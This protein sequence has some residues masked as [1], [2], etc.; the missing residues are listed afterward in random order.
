MTS[1]RIS[2]S[3][4]ITVISQVGSRY[5]G[6]DVMRRILPV[7]A[8]PCQKTTPGLT[9]RKTLDK[10]RLK[11]LLQ[12]TTLI[13]LQTLSNQEN[14]RNCYSQEQSKRHDKSSPRALRMESWDR[15]KALARELP[16]GLVVWIWCLYCQGLGS[17]HR[18]TATSTELTLFGPTSAPIL[19]LITRSC[20]FTC[21]S[22]FSVL[23]CELLSK[24]GAWYHPSPSPSPLSS[25]APSS[26]LPPPAEMPRPSKCLLNGMEPKCN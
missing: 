6:F 23:A 12:S 21:L 18:I 17:Q 25:L 16:G 15:T 26:S 8:L 4:S 10:F 9:M 13:L 24:V 7:C 1:A 20:V 11:D 14:L 2:R 19:S 3:T 5:L 22:L